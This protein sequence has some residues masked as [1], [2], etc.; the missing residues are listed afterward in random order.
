MV[1]KKKAGLTVT[2]SRRYNIPLNLWLVAITRTHKQHNQDRRYNIQKSQ[3][4]TT[5][6]DATISKNHR[7]KQV[8]LWV[9]GCFVTKRWR[10]YCSNTRVSEWKLAGPILHRI[11]EFNS[12]LETRSQDDT[13]D[14][15][16]L[17]NIMQKET[18][19]R[20]SN[21]HIKKPANRSDDFLW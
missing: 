4:K 6:I 11:L 9:H 3:E 1:L 20:N 10:M 12:T 5:K 21:R 19:T 2:G 15:I 17:S 8:A 7:K 16:S 14:T 13:L 18:K